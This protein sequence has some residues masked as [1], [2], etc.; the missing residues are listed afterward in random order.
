MIDGR[1][2]FRL[3][4][5]TGANRTVLA[6]RTA[7]ELAAPPV[8]GRGLV[9]GVTGAA[10]ARLIEVGALDVGRFSR[11]DIVVAALPG[12]FFGGIDGILGMDGLAGQRISVDFR[13][14]R[15]VIGRGGGMIADGFIRLKGRLQNG[16]LLLTE[17]KVAGVKAVAIVDTGAERTTGNAALQ[18]A[19]LAS[20]GGA[21]ALG[22]IE[23]LGASGETVR[24]EAMA[25]PHIAIGGLRVA[26]LNAVMADAYIFRFWNMTSEPALLL[27][28]DV[29]GQADALMIDYRTATLWIKPPDR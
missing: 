27:G 9:L 3:M 22:P 23:L 7:A 28:M 24:G 21:R 15:I 25:I 12:E 16:A 13:R 18:Q 11:R 5:D 1:G 20:S 2:P 14:D 17:A 19:L 26:N 6:E 29:L 10:E 8:R 4:V